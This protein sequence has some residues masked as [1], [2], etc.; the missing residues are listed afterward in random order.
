VRGLDFEEHFLR[1]R[2]AILAV[3]EDDQ[4]GG[5]KRELCAR[6]GARYHVLEK[7]PPSFTPVRVTTSPIRGRVSPDRRAS[8]IPPK[9][10]IS[11]NAASGS[12]MRSPRDSFSRLS[13]LPALVRDHAQRM[14]RVP[15][16]T[17]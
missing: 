10:S 2:P 5:L 8:Q 7:R 15:C 3:T 9:S 13:V 17:F 14:Q 12:P 16:L 1:L 4:Y 11:A 6:V